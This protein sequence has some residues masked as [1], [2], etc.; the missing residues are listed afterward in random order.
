LLKLFED[1]P[2]NIF[3]VLCTTDKNAILPAIVSR[4]LTLEFNTKSKEEVISNL[5]K[6]ANSRNINLPEAVANLIALRSKGHMRDAHKL[7]E[8]FLL[9]GENDFLNLEESGYVYLAKYFAQV[10]WLV[11]NIRAS[12][13]EIKKHKEIMMEIVDRLMR[14]PIAL[15]KDDYQNLFLDLAKKCFNQEYKTEPIIDAIIKQFDVRSIMNLYKVA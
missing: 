6:I 14:I 4:S 1:A 15:L 9:I 7:F 12:S 11:K 3:Y 5:Y 10:L 13:D 2:P 8:K